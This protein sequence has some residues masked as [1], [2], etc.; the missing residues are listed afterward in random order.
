MEFPVILTRRSLLGTSAAALLAAAAPRRALAALPEIVPASALQSDLDLLRHAYEAVHPGLRRYLTHSAFRG[1][2]ERAKAWA[3]RERRPGEVFL[4]LAR[5][6]AAVRCG[7]T[8]PNPVNQSR[9]VR[10]ALL[11]GRDRLPLTFKWIGSRMVVTGGRGGHTPLPVGTEILDLDGVTPV[12]LL[13]RLMPLARADGSNDHKRLDQLGLRPHGRFQA[14]DI[15]RPMLVPTSSAHLRLRVRAPGGQPA[16]IELP[17]LSEDELRVGRQENSPNLGWTFAIDELGI[18][19]LAMPSWVTFNSKWDWQAYIDA[20]VDR[21]ID[22]RARGL[23]LDLRGNEGGSDCGWHLLERLVSRQVALPRYVRRTRYRTLPDALRGP[24][25]TWD[26]S[27]RDW[28]ASARGPDSDGFYLLEREGADTEVVRPRG[29]RFEKPL[30]VIVDAS[31]SSATFQFA[32]AVRETGVARLIGE[33]TG[34]NRRGINGGA[35]YFLRLPA[36]GFEVDLPIIGYFPEE[37]QSDGGVVPHERV[38]VRAEDIASG[39]DRQME[40][41]VRRLG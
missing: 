11:S 5:L 41:A 35:F 31:C 23:I 30:A 16:A 36:T 20:V 10:D 14:F 18:G 1:V 29:R 13:S 25:D 33:T 6:T 40:L 22:E 34:G 39:I 26:D 15:F 24:L 4:M 19:R 32:N 9:S 21:L 27:F 8:F 28:G 17:A 7:H 2:V 38:P 37:R 12:E 3:D